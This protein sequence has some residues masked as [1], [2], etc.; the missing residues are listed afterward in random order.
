MP[1]QKGDHYENLQKLKALFFKDNHPVSL[2]LAA[3]EIKEG[4]AYLHPKEDHTLA[5]LVKSD[6]IEIRLSKGKSLTD[7]DI[8]VIGKL[9]MELADKPSSRILRIMFSKS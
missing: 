8:L 5:Y 3:A 7:Q 4:K 9:L 2:D 6:D 1:L